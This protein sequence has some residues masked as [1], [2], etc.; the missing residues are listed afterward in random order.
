MGAGSSVD[1]VAPEGTRD[2]KTVLKKGLESGMSQALNASAAAHPEWR[3]VPPTI[4]EI[5]R[6]SSTQVPYGNS[7]SISEEVM[8]TL[9]GRGKGDFT[10]EH[11]EWK[12]KF[13]IG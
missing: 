8:A 6:R 3:Q 1:R 5:L 10:G 11:A 12:G 9:P 2:A 7:T 4:S 13:Y